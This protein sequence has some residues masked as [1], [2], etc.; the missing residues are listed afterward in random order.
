MPR[1][2]VLAALAAL[3]PL[4]ASA[5]EVVVFAAASLKSAL[6]GVA[7]EFTSGPAIR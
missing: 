2:L 4:A 7:A 1:P 3:A 6:D 5:D